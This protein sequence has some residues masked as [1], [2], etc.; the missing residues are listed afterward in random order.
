MKKLLLTLS[1]VILLSGMGLS[2]T[3]C[4]QNS[5]SCESCKRAHPEYFQHEDPWVPQ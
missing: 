1:V 2:I 5:G 4:A 3:G